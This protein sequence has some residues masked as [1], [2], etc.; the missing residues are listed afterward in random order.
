MEMKVTFISAHELVS[1]VEKKGTITYYPS[2]ETVYFSELVRK[3]AVPNEVF[4]RGKVFNSY[5]LKSGKISLN[6]RV[7][8]CDNLNE[9]YM[10]MRKE[11]EEIF[12]K[13]RLAEQ[14]K[15]SVAK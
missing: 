13:L 11:L 15:H 8:Q 7:D 6:A 10:Y 4:Y 12:D 2:S 1:F 5:V 14:N 3:A 9:A